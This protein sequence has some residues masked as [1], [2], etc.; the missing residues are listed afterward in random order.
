MHVGTPRLGLRLVLSGPMHRSRCPGN[1]EH[2]IL[3]THTVCQAQ[4]QTHVRTCMCTGAATHPSLSS[5]LYYSL[6][7]LSLTFRY[8]GYI[9]FPAI[10][11]CTRVM[12]DKFWRLAGWANLLDIVPNSTHTHTHTHSPWSFPISRT[13][14]LRFLCNSV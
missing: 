8:G 11:E 9:A 2:V 3:A 4:T 10:V 14:S 12:G 1:N 6:R 13:Y 7:P 5:E